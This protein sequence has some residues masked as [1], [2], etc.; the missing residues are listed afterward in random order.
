MHVT[1][2]RSPQS[3]FGIYICMH[4][5]E[6]VHDGQQ[7]T[8]RGTEVVRAAAGLTYSTVV[9]AAPALAGTAA[10][11]D[12]HQLLTAGL[13]GHHHILAATVCSTRGTACSAHQPFRVKA[14]EGTRLQLI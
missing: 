6:A 13:R 12:L 7:T 9:H 11:L 10:L 4:V 8:G 1:R 3:P 5:T 14:V 2:G